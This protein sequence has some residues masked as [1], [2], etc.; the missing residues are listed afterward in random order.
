M[1]ALAGVAASAAVAQ[2]RGTDKKK[3]FSPLHDFLGIDPESGQFVGPKTAPAAPSEGSRPSESGP[4]ADGPDGRAASAAA[5]SPTDPRVRSAED[6]PKDAEEAA[7]AVRRMAQRINEGSLDDLSSLVD[8]RFSPGNLKVLSRRF[9]WITGALLLLYPL[10]IVVSEMLGWWFRR[11]ESGLTDFDRRYQRSRL[12][13]RLLMASTLMALIVLATIG[14]VN[15]YWWGQP[16]LLTLFCIVIGVLCIAAATLSSMI[17]QSAKQY[18]LT[19][20]R[21]MRRE[22]LEM[23]AELDELCKRM[24]QVTMTSD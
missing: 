14:S 21:Q 6:L 13:R 8:E 5:D 15:G 24:R 4:A 12:T 3:P 11:Q 18:S 7:E 23:R 1:I 17:K 16:K 22:Q 10:S 9:A 20:M 2:D 19:L